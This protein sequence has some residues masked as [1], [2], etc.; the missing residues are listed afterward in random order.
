MEFQLGSFSFGLMIWQ[1]IL[2]VSLFFWLF[3]V[4]D[5][6]RNSFNSNDKLVW[7]LVL[8]FVPILGPFLYFF[9]GRKKRIINN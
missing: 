5:V 2:F 1:I 7:I 4:I 6:L 9:I 3:C 8:L